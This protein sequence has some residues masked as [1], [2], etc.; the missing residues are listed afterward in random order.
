MKRKAKWRRRARGWKQTVALIDARPAELN[1]VAHGY[2]GALNGDELWVGFGDELGELALAKLTFRH[3][4]TAGQAYCKGIRLKI[5][6]VAN[7]Q[8]PM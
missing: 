2:S 4:K 3:S 7:P 8:H 6:V 1:L 5:K